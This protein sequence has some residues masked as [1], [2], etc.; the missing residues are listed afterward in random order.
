VRTAA[1][2]APRRATYGGRAGL[3]YVQLLAVWK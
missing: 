1:R 3:E 2:M